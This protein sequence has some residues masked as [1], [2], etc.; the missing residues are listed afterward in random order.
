VIAPRCIACSVDRPG[1][2]PADDEYVIKSF[3]CPKCKTVVRLVEPYST[4]HS[5]Q[6]VH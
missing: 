5:S 1:A 4:E 6:A 3:E 2:M